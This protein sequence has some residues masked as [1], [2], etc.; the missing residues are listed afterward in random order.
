MTAIA[1][2]DGFVF[3]QLP[4][5]TYSDGDVTVTATEI[6]SNGRDS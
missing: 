1:T 3:W 6:L 4:D 5:G 2:V